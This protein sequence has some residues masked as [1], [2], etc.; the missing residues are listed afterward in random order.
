MVG[1]PAI[2]HFMKGNHN[3]G[4]SDNG[5]SCTSLKTV[6]FPKLATL[7]NTYTFSGCT[8]LETVEIGGAITSFP[9]YCFYNCKKLKALVLSGITSV[10]TF[11]TSMFSNATLMQAKTGVIYVPSNLVSSFTGSWANYNIQDIAN[12]VA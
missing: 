12:Y 2:F 5:D 1:K 8:K 7:R 11:G 9:N 4:I 6:S 3:E 10:P